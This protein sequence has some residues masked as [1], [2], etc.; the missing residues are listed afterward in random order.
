MQSEREHCRRQT[1]LKQK[2][3]FRQHGFSLIESLIGITIG[4]FI[5][6]GSLALMSN[7]M[8]SNR[9]LILETRL[10]QNLRTSADLI[11]RDIRR[12]GY[13]A[14]AAKGVY[15]PGDNA[16]IPQNRYANLIPGSCDDPT[17]ATSVPSPQSSTSLSSL[18]YYIE[19]G[20]PD[21]SVSTAEMFGFKLINGVL[22]A[23]V[24]GSTPQP[25]SD[26]DSVTIT[27]FILKPLPV[28]ILLSSNCS[29]TPAIT[30]K[31]VIREFEVEVRGYLPSDSSL[32]RG[33][34]TKV[35]VRNNAVSG[36][37]SPT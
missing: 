23:F 15:V 35:K 10:I 28:E 8:T 26:P 3:N 36:S 13:W 1:M 5:V 30:P 21:N 22:Y 24:A 4:L 9:T 7:I 27:Q 37:C 29:I 19:Q 12:A 14:D 16:A 34:R 6:T 33:I 20:T 2:T 11:V 32:I 25:L 31:V 18:C 17:L